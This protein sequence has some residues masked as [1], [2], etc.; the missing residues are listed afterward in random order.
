MSFI[1]KL[2]RFYLVV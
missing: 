1:L 2:T